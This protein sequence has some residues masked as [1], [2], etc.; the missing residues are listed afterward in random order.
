MRKETA[1][2]AVRMKR[3][4]LVTRA[5]VSRTSRSR[6]LERYLESRLECNEIGV[7]SIMCP[8]WLPTENQTEY[9]GSGQVFTVC[10]GVVRDATGDA[11]KGTAQTQS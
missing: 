10:G 7:G 1:E 8:T 4:K 11:A 3:A 6:R 2:K 5:R 9:S